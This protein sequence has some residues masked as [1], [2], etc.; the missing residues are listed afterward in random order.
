MAYNTTPPARQHSA[1]F[2]LLLAK[3]FSL[4]RVF[5]KIP[6]LLHDRN[7]SSAAAFLHYFAADLFC[8]IVFITISEID[9]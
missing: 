6:N 2:A 7:V 3:A 4:R 1:I 8:A 5:Q 9:G